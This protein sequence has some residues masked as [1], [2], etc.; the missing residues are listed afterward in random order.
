MDRPRGVS[1]LKLYVC[2]QQHRES[3]DRPRGA[4]ELKSVGH[5]KF[6]STIT[7]RPPRGE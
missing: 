6:V 1:E 3:K 2:V 5:E 4:S 7:D